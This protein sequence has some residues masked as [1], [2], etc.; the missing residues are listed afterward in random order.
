MQSSFDLSSPLSL[1]QVVDLCAQMN[2]NHH[3]YTIVL[4]RDGFIEL[5]SITS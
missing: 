1:Q 3:L 2:M 5:V 4:F